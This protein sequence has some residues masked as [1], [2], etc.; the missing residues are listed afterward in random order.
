MHEPQ[1]VRLGGMYVVVL[2]GAS[3][4][5]TIMDLKLQEVVSKTTALFVGGCSALSVRR[6]RS[7]WWV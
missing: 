7:C 1:K 6:Q 4:H 3:I 5:E 2:S